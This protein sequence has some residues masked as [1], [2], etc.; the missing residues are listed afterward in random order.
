MGA[1]LFEIIVNHKNKLALNFE[2]IKREK[3]KSDGK[4]Q[5]RKCKPKGYFRVWGQNR[6]WGCFG[7]WGGAQNFRKKLGLK[8]G[9]K[10]LCQNFIF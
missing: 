7:E 2:C 5:E 10:I 4:S 3:S 8:N 1:S 6:E 9:L